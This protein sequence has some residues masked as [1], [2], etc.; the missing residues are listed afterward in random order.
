MKR[1]IPTIYHNPRCSS[2]RKALAILSGRDANVVRYL[3]DP[4]TVIELDRI[5]RLL[6]VPPTELVRVKESRFGE[7][8]LSLDDDRGREE[9]LRII[10]ENPML[11]ERPI[12]ILGDRAVVGR[13]P[14]KVLD[15]L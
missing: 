5:C 4:P 13:P 9:W 1:P 8:G 3:E 14:E 15:L 7:L 6:E 11:L 10:V 12:V 2:S